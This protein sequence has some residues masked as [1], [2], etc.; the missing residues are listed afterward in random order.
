MIRLTQLFPLLAI[1]ISVLAWQYPDLFTPY[2]SWIVP[3]L[4]VVM[5]GM[6]LTLHLSDFSNI[7][8]MPQ[9]VIAGVVL[10]EWVLIRR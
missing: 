2:K 8:Q 9:L 6:G 10:P 7:L 4:A 3:L 5:F 1:I